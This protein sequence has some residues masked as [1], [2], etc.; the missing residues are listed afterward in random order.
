MNRFLSLKR[1]IIFDLD[2][3]LVDTNPYHTE[4]F[5]KVLIKRGIPFDNYSKYAGMSTSNLLKSLFKDKKIPYDEKVIEE[6][7]KEKQDYV[8]KL[9]KNIKPVPFAEKYLQ[10]LKE[11]KYKLVVATSASRNRAKFILK[12][13]NLLKYFEFILSEEDVENNKPSPDI[14]LKAIKKLGALPEEAIVI[15]DSLNGIKAAKSAEVQV[16]AI[17]TTHSKEELSPADF[18]VT[19][20]EEL[21]LSLNYNFGKY[22]VTYNEAYEAIKTLKEVKPIKRTTALILAAGEGTRLKYSKPK[23]LYPILGKPILQHLYDKLK[24]VCDKQVLVVSPSGYAVINDY[25]KKQDLNITLAIQ[26]RPTGMG[27]AILS[28]EDKIGPETE[29]VL[30]L[31]GDQVAIE[32][33]TL[34][35][36]LYFHQNFK[37]GIADF[38]FPICIKKNP[39]IHFKRNHQG[40]IIE[41]LQKR[42]QDNMP[43]FGEND[44]GFFI[45]KKSIFNELKEFKKTRPLSTVTQEFNF[46]PIIPNLVNKGLTVLTVNCAKDYETIG[47]N[48]L[49]EAKFHEKIM[50]KKEKIKVVLFCGGRGGKNI[51]NELVK[52]KI[53]DLSIIVNAYDDGLSTGYLRRLIPGFLGPSDVRKNMARLIDTSTEHKR[54]LK[55]LIEFRFPKVTNDSEDFNDLKNII[56]NK[57]LK[58]DTLNIFIKKISLIDLEYIQK[59]LKY[60]INYLIKNKIKF[61]FSDCS[62]GNIL[63]SGCFLKE[64]SF[65][66]TI[67]E[68]SKFLE[69]KGQLIN[70]T[71]GENLALCAIKGD[72]EFL[73][74]EASIVEK[75]ANVELEDFFLLNDYFTK[76]EIKRLD[77]FNIKKKIDFLR[78]I[79]RLPEIGKEAHKTIQEA[80]IIIFCPGTQYS[81][82]LPSYI[83]KGVAEALVSNRKGKKIFISNIGE[84]NEIPKATADDLI[85][86][87]VYYLNRRGEC[88]YKTE[89]LID[90]FLINKKKNITLNKSSSKYIEFK[91]SKKYKNVV[92]QDFEENDSGK[93]DGVKITEKIMGLV[94]STHNAGRS[95]EIKK[96]SIIVPAYNE[97]RYINEVINNVKKVDLSEFNIIKEIIVVDDGSKDN[98]YS[99]IKDIEGITTERFEK[100]KGKGAAVN[101][102]IQLATGDIILIQDADLEYD[103]KDIKEMLS[104]MFKYNFR[105]VYGSRGMKEGA[106][107]KALN[108]LYGKNKAA[109]WSYYLG[110]Q[111][112]SIFTF[113]LYGKFLTDP[114]VAYK[115]YDAKIIKNFKI[116]TRG[117]ETDHELTAKVFKKGIDIYEIPITYNPRTK[118]EGKK[119]SW[120]DGIIALFTLLRFRFFD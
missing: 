82:L 75:K 27:D 78:E 4:A 51:I 85:E 45:A 114:A 88:N 72:N 73:P 46:L 29:D 79:E 3:V 33:N 35:S 108:I 111:L 52:H 21:Y 98:T 59:Y 100:N 92:Y 10:L 41:V 63:L 34:D 116:K 89:E 23:I 9:M 112:L 110:G 19:G 32:K 26:P 101:R 12:K 107:F 6:L 57:E 103:P 5:K 106:R 58:N 105:V 14:Y 77:K 7:K 8:L 96:L 47:V 104:A 70:I 50:N 67:S 69:I 119:I 18:I 39:Y 71:S 115:M 48:T 86:K 87:A 42:E 68:F 38:T 91:N 44:C 56:K 30:I 117:F 102:G 61:Q 1:A 66:K 109:Y 31:W 83:T 55:E 65:N 84:D 97:A 120:K 2:G 113:F 53:F 43:S 40:N 95:K 11:K 90:Y 36:S 94:H 60:F 64:K 15:E 76:K 16:I 54:I 20:F 49:E 93:H 22:H 118:E 17:T 13:T 81:S 37:N 80:D 24:S 99:I 74:S 25:I 28:A 62:L